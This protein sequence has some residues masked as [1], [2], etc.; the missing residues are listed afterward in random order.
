MVN[1]N[2]DIN[3][4]LSMALARLS[5][6]LFLANRISCDW[7]R[8]TEGEQ[9]ILNQKKKAGKSRPFSW[10]FRAGQAGAIAVTGQVSTHAPQSMQVSASIALFSPT[11]LMALVGQESSHAPQLM[12]S[13]DIT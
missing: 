6:A 4:C 5:R 10:A 9:I 8:D 3:T 2:V 11:S 1:L 7:D 13:S 12:H